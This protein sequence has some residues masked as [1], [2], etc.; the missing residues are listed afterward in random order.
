MS[1]CATKHLSRHRHREGRSS[2]VFRSKSKCQWLC[3]LMRLAVFHLVTEQP[4]RSYFVMPISEREERASDASARYSRLVVY[5]VVTSSLLSIRPRK[6]RFRKAVL[7]LKNCLKQLSS[8][9]FP[10]P[11]QS[12]HRDKIVCSRKLQLLRNT[13]NHKEPCLNLC[14]D[15]PDERRSVVRIL[16]ETSSR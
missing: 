16:L 10:R 11:K 2:D 3:L 15:Q 7:F 6:H 8:I 9:S 1:T 13:L 5:Q 14:A 4:R 12:I